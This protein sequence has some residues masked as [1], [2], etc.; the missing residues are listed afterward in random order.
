MATSVKTSSDYNWGYLN[1]DGTWGP[2]GTPNNTSESTVGTGTLGKDAFLK[3][4]T[5]QMQY[6]DPLNPTSDTEWIAQMAQ[7][8]ALEAMQNMAQTTENTQA[9]QLVG[10]YV[11]I[12]ENSGIGAPKL[13]AGMV[14]YVTIQGGKAYIN[15]DGK[16]YSYDMLDSVVSN[17]YIK[18]LA[19]SDAA[20]KATTDDIVKLLQN[21]L[22]YSGS[23]LTTMQYISSLLGGK[24]S[25]DS[26]NETTG[27][28]Q[29]KTDSDDTTKGPAD[30]ETEETDNKTDTT[31]TPENAAGTTE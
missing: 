22:S 27:P 7:F 11:I 5:T 18:V 30:T 2:Q 12:D 6:Q 8:S 14:D 24:N 19:E 21:I 31:K 4:L 15:M 26:S 16:T 29:D 9:F 28:N 23:S 20:G 10:Q 13:T 1:P 3:L 17:D 25:S